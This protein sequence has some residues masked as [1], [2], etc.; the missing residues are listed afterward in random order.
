[1]ALFTE[2]PHGSPRNVWQA[3]VADAAPVGHRL[4][5]RLRAVD[6]DTGPAQVVAEVTAEASADLDLRP[7]CVV[8]VSVKASEGVLTAL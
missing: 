1:V 2:Q 5:V 6:A 8:W 4:R 3:T 7:G